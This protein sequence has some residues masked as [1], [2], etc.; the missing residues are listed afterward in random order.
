MFGSKNDMN[1]RQRAHKS[2]RWAGCLAVLMVVFAISASAAP[3]AS[4]KKSK[5]KTPAPMVLGMVTG[6]ETGTYIEIGQDIAKTMKPEGVTVDVKSSDGSIANIR[7]IQSKEN[8]AIGIVQSDVLG[9]LKRSKNPDTAKIASSLR[10]VLPLYK[11]EVHVLAR[12]DIRRF[13]DLKGKRVVVGEE[14]SGNMLTAVNLLA[15]MNIKVADTQKLAPPEGL[16]AVLD[17][18]ADAVIFVSG[19]PV[20]LFKN[21][22]ALNRPENLQYAYLLRDLHFIALDNPKM[23]AEY[24]PSEITPMDYSFVG[25]PIATIAVRAILVSYDFTG[26]TAE[27]RKRCQAI[28]KMVRVL[29]EKLPELKKNHHPKWREVDFSRNLNLWKRDGCVV[30]SS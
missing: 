25:E 14:G 11:E 12:K 21:M 13:E 8:A 19:K 18:Q 2:A 10:M 20:K 30:P 4:P 5:E 24:E 15:L 1:C 26:K 17:N 3:K 7:R 9:F 27:K 6:P 22:E 28:G 29:N 16:L 23:L